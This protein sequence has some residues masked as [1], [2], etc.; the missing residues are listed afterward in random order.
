ML[1]GVKLKE[2]PFLSL[3][4]P[5]HYKEK[6]CNGQT[7]GFS[8][9]FFDQSSVIFREDSLS[10]LPKKA[11]T[12]QQKPEERIWECEIAWQRG[13]CRTAIKG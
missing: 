3:I 4:N 13:G 7:M 5:S 12:G 11:E 6:I 2:N 10:L 8:E 1:G 9:G